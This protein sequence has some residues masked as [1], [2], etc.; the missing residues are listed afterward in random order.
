MVQVYI[1]DA[2]DRINKAGKEALLSFAEGDELRMMLMGM[3]RFTKTQP[4]NIKELRR[5]VAEHIISVNK[6]SL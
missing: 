6:Y 3:K 4:Q 2:A 1:H 5:K